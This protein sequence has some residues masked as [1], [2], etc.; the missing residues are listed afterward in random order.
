MAYDDCVGTHCLEGKSGVFQAL[1]L[2][3][4][5]ALGREVD[6]VGGQPLRRCLEGDA[7]ARG[8]LE[9][10]VDDRAAAQRR[11]LLDRPVG[12]LRELF[13]R[14]EN[15]QRVVVGQVRCRQQVA[16]H[17]DSSERLPSRTAS[18]PSYS[19]RWTFTVSLSDVGMFLPT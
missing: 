7:G 16:L 8:V 5:R 19:A 3:D 18:R 2:G 9:E 11:E 6:D 15:E 1:A 17:A 14:V 12:N 4:A 10:E 13:C